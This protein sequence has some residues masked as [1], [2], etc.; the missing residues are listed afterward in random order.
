MPD[1]EDQYLTDAGFAASV[2]TLHDRWKAHMIDEGYES[3]GSL[4]DMLRA[5][6][7]V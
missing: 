7:R 1:L 5:W 2:G 4:A 3:V 6:S